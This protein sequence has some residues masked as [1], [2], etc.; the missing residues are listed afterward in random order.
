MTNLTDVIGQFKSAMVA[1]GLIP[2]TDLI[3]DGRIHRCDAKGKGGRSDGAYLLHADGIPAGGIENHRDGVGWQGWRADIGRKLTP[4]EEAAHRSKIDAARQQR[5]AED[6][7]RKSAARATAEHLWS[8]AKPCEAH[9]YLTKKRLS[10]AHG[11]RLHGDKLLIPLRD[12]TGVLHSLQTIEADG[13]KRFLPGG[14]IRGCYFG[15]GGKP[16]GMLVIAEGFA[17]GASIY[18]ATAYPVAAALNTGNLMAVARAMRCKFPG[19]RIIIGADDDFETAG[20]PGL[21]KAVEAAKAIGADVA[22]P[23]FGRTPA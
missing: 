5:D 7:Q 16:E 12:E 11:A 14:R 9:P 6:A 15:I 17:T 10:S 3:A 19:I 23:D 18:E 4:A 2:P 1:R 13:G 20:N 8:E 21:T 22:I